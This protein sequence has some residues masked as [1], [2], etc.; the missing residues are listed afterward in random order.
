MKRRNFLKGM[1][2]AP[3]VVIAPA[4]LADTAQGKLPW[5]GIDLANGQD[6]TA[7]LHKAIND[8]MLYGQSFIEFPKVVDAHNRTN[9]MYRTIIDGMEK[10]NGKYV[11]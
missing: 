11:S 4:L 9:L 7:V 2:A 10:D 3:A 8:A 6:S 1:A 5:M